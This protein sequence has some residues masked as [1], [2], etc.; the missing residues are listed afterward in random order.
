MSKGSRVID[1]AGNFMVRKPHINRGLFVDRVLRI[2]GP[3][4]ACSVRARSV[5]KSFR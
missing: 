4:G 5:D 3:A 2:A 1:E